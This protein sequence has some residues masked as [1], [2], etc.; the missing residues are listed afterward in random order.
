M[1]A[2]AA[3]EISEDEPLEESPSEAGDSEF[4]RMEWWDTVHW[5]RILHL[6]AKTTAMIPSSMKHA[7]AEFKGR[8]C[9][10]IEEAASQRRRAEEERCWKLLLASD[11]LLFAEN[12]ESTQGSRRTAIAEKLAWIEGGQWDAVCSMADD[13]GK[14]SGDMRDPMEAAVKLIEDLMKEGELSRA[15]ATVWAATAAD[16]ATQVADKFAQTQA[17]PVPDGPPLPQ[18]QPGQAE[19][20]KRR[21]QAQIKKSF[22][23]FAR[24]G[25]AGPGGGRYEHWEALAGDPDLA[26]AVAG[27]LARLAVG[28]LPPDAMRACLAAR[29]AGIPKASGGL[30]VLGCGGVIRRMVARAAAKAC[31][32]ELRA[33]GGPQQY[34]LSDDGTGKLHRKPTALTAVRPGVV[35]MALDIA[36]AFSTVD[37]RAVVEAVASGVPVLLPLAEQWLQGEVFHVAGA[38]GDEV[39]GAMGR[40]MDGK[41]DKATGRIMNGAADEGDEAGECDEYLHVVV[42]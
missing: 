28:H 1:P 7:V 9:R 32:A 33:A 18:P 4:P 24:R 19:A 23:R 37:R 39:D 38:A 25:G 8:I 5:E 20:L 35:V 40:I 14:G 15:A 13:R 26:D 36:D 27:T 31:K 6:A 3:S 16:T 10:S 42:M 22:A 21:V 11:G 30:R 34:G 41:A 2:D 29:L 17:R 12:S